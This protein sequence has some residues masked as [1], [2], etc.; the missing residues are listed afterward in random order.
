MEKESLWVDII[1]GQLLS[2][3]TSKEFICIY[4]SKNLLYVNYHNGK[5]AELPF[6]IKNCCFIKINQNSDIMMVK[7][8]GDLKVYNLKSRV[9]S[10]TDNIIELYS[11]YLKEK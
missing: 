8:N 7:D 4:T 10:F 3:E 1:E 9:T 5:R 2:I 6:F 11:V